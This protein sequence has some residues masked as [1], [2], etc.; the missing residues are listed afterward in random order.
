[1]LPAGQVRQFFAIAYP[2]Q[3]IELYSHASFRACRRRSS[4]LR[5]DRVVFVPS[6]SNTAAYTGIVAASDRDVGV[7]V[8]FRRRGHHCSV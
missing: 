1:M 5:R 2:C 7:L 6:L 8:E 3:G 4:A